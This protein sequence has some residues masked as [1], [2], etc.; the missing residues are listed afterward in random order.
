LERSALRAVVWDD[1]PGVIYVN[2]EGPNGHPDPVAAIASISP[3][4]PELRDERTWRT[5][6][7]IVVASSALMR[8]VS[9]SASLAYV[10]T[11]ADELEELSHAARGCK[12][13]PLY[14]RATQ[15]VF[16][17]GPTPAPLLFVGEQPGDQEDKQGHPFVGP[18][19][20]VLDAALEDANIP[21]DQIF[22]TNAVKHFKWEPRGKRRLHSR[23]NAAEVHACNGWLQAEVRLVQP[24]AIVC[25]GATAAQALLGRKFRLTEHR[26]ERLDG[27]PWAPYI[28]ATLHPSALLRMMSDRAAYEREKDAFV[29]DLEAARSLVTFR[30]TRGRIATALEH[31]RRHA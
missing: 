31:A 16:G 11:D 6:L 5:P 23:P 20:R 7:G 14:E 24:R 22:V 9:P 17:E 10:P 19:G 15:T 12:A 27:A 30:R 3:D 25:L 29:R 1:L 2:P 4:A 13:C 18:A 28:V 21:R 26:G 8:S